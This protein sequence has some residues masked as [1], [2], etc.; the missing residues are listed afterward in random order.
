L[1]VESPR[2]LARRACPRCDGAL[3]RTRRTAVDRLLS[4]VT[5]R[6]RYRCRSLSCGWEGTLPLGGPA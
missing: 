4:L 6:R 3:V 2:L 1:I 5:P